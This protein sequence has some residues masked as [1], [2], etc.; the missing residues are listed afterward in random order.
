MTQHLDV[1]LFSEGP[2]APLVLGAKH[3]SNAVCIS[4]N[5]IV[6][7]LQTSFALGGQQDDELDSSNLSSKVLPCIPF[8]TMYHSRPA[9]PV[10]E[11]SDSIH[12]AIGM[13]MRAL[14]LI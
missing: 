13:R 14:D 12:R 7:G 6:F 5:A 3:V 9:R 2:G 4:L 8:S 11:G 10:F 1:R